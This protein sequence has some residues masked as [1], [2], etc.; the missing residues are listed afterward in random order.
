MQFGSAVTEYL[1]PGLPLT[2]VLVYGYDGLFDGELKKIIE[3]Q[4]DAA[5][6]AINGLVL[7]AFSYMLGVLVH[8]IARWALKGTVTGVER[9]MWEDF[10]RYCSPEA[11]SVL[12]DRVD[13]E[14]Q[15]ATAG[16]SEG[17]EQRGRD[18]GW[19]LWRMRLFLCH[20][21]PGCSREI[22]RLQAISRV[23]RGALALPAAL[24]IWAL[25]EV[26]RVVGEKWVW[27]LDVAVRVALVALAVV[28]GHLVVRT[29]DYRWG[30]VTRATIAAFIGFSAGPAGGGPPRPTSA[31]GPVPENVTERASS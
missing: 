4:Q 30:T 26:A 18:P 29:Y 19:L 17:D 13:M 27:N 10:G 23:A 28:L 24:G 1:L 2:V 11:L 14:V 8:F 21:S 3:G 5:V 22:F 25:L 9:G 20:H 6:L 16:E 7:L 15:R 31:G 12:G